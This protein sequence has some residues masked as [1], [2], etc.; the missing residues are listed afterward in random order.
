MTGT[1]SPRICYRD[2]VMGDVHLSFAART[3]YYKIDFYCR[4][5]GAWEMKLKTLAAAVGIADSNLRI[6]IAA[7]VKAGYLRVERHSHSQKFIT[8]W[9]DRLNQANAYNKGSR[10]A[11]SARIMVSA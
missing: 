10:F 4:E 9:C 2:C 7:L 5:A 8:G 1:N 6:A 11:Q 3:V